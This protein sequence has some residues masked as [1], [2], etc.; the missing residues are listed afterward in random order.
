MSFPSALD[1]MSPLK[2]RSSMLNT[3]SAPF[4]S[5]T[6]NL[7]AT[8][9]QFELNNGAQQIPDTTLIMSTT[10]STSVAASA[11]TVY[12]T[13]R[14]TVGPMAPVAVHCQNKSSK[15]RKRNRYRSSSSYSSDMDVS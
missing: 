4:V 13:V 5:P 11:P 3:G 10:P 12:D 7:Q 6:G 9:K 14:T 1:A 8:S 2:P 15:R